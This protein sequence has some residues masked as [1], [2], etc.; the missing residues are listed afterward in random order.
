M[1]RSK[2]AVP[3]NGL[4]AE[5]YPLV[6]RAARVRSGRLLSALRAAALDPSDLEQE[7]MLAVLTALLDFDDRRSSLA[8]YVDRIA[9][10]KTTSVLR[11][12]A[13]KKRSRK[14]GLPPIREPLLV[15]VAVERRLDLERALKKLGKKDR[16]VARSLAAYT[17]AEAARLLQVSRPAIYRSKDRIRQVLLQAGF[18]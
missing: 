5:A 1:A 17:P 3:I 8:T 18:R 15:L 13:A 10:S 12:T 4:L 11:K 16:K 2:G 6:Q 9:E 7:I 14:N